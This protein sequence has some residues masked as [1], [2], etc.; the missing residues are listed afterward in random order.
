MAAQDSL[1]QEYA[2]VKTNSLQVA[3]K[4]KFPRAIPFNATSPEISQ[5][6]TDI[7]PI[8][9]DIETKVITGGSK[10]T[11]E[12]GFEQMQNERK[13]LGYSNIEK[14]IQEWYD[15]NKASFNK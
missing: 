3:M 9:E 1:S 8:R 5:F 15:K 10:Y 2:K 7:A 4:N 13:R 11:V 14:I 12:W 6:N